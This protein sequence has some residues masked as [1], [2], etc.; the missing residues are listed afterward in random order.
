MENVCNDESPQKCTLLLWGKRCVMTNTQVAY[1][2]MQNEREKLAEQKRS[3][4]AQEA[5]KGRELDELVRSNTARETETNRSNVV[6]E[7]ETQRSN[8]AQERE[9]NRANMAR[10]AETTRSNWAKETETRRANVARETETTRSNLAKEIENYR[11][12][13]A[14]ER[15]TQRHNMAEESRIPSEVK[16]NTSKSQESDSKAKLNEAATAQTKV[17]TA[18]GVL[19]TIGTGVDLISDWLFPAKGIAKFLVPQAKAIGSA[20]M[21]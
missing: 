2:Q 1:W 21:Y 14:R 20:F 15:E 12:N 6:R 17:D 13:S 5:L 9:T 16:V 11:S 18:H 4:T 8:Q 19:D 3:N 10:E 7:I